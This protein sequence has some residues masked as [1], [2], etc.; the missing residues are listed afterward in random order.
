LGLNPKASFWTCSTCPLPKQSLVGKIGKGYECFHQDVPDNTYKWLISL[1]QTECSKIYVKKCCLLNHKLAKG[2]RVQIC[3]FVLTC[4]IKHIIFGKICII[5]II[6]IITTTTTTT[7]TA[8]V[9]IV[10]IIIIIIIIIHKCPSVCCT[11]SRHFQ[12]ELRSE[13]RYKINMVNTVTNYVQLE[14]LG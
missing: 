10:L 7:T 2:R 5:I 6:I 12:L 14:W 13:T 8:V 9:V 1:Y 3:I 11:I 4:S